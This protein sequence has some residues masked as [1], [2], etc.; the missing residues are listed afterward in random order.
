MYVKNGHWASPSFEVEPKEGES[1]LRFWAELAKTSEE[2]DSYQ[3][4]DQ[5]SS[6][7]EWYR[8]QIE[9]GARK[10]TYTLCRTCPGGNRTLYST[11]DADSKGNSNSKKYAFQ[12]GSVYENDDTVENDDG[13]ME[14]VAVHV[15]DGFSSGS[16]SEKTPQSG[17]SFQLLLE[18]TN[19]LSFWIR[20]LFIDCCSK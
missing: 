11:A 9:T 15:P 16:F 19:G 10:V 3:D 1:T 2:K 17:T 14:P 20:Y 7:W 8:E 5:T 4:I 13:Y 12:R 18:N 6:V